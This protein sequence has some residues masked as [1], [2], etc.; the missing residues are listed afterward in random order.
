MP[1]WLHEG[2]AQFCEP[3]HILSTADRRFLRSYVNEHGGFK[4]EDIDAMFVKKGDYDAIRAAYLE[5]KLFVEYLID[6]YRKQNLKRLFES[7]K[8]SADWQKALVEVYQRNAEYFDERFNIY[9]TK[10]LE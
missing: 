7:L 4:L 2:F 3:K 8:S 5:S 6:D 1:S 10:T 9:L